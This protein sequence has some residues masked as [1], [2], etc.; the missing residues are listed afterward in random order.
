M[1]K[2]LEQNVNLSSYQGKWYEI[3]STLQRFQPSTGRN[4]GRTYTLRKSDQ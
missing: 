3:A 4:C 1:L 2:T